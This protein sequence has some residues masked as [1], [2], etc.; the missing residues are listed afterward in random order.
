MLDFEIYFEYDN[1]P[2][3]DTP[4]L[5]FSKNPK[6]MSYLKDKYPDRR[7]IP[8]DSPKLDIG[9][10][11]EILAKSFRLYAKYESDFDKC[12]NTFNKLKL[13]EKM[14][15]CVTQECMEEVL[16]AVDKRTVFL[17]QLIARGPTVDPIT[18]KVLYTFIIRGHF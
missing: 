17:Y 3:T 5:T 8:M 15:S 7:F 6:L 14:F 18:F 16:A 9:C 12:D 10:G 13:T 1:V 4:K 2:F 11:E